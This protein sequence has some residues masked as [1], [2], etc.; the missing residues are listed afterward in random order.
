MYVIELSE[1]AQKFLDRFDE[2][3]KERIK[4]SLKKLELNPI[5]HDVKFIRRVNGNKL[6]R[7]RIGNYRVLYVVEGELVLITKIDK[8]SRV[9]D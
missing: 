5:P 2:Y 1:R 3:V 8:R 4:K 6:F 9:Y 7:I